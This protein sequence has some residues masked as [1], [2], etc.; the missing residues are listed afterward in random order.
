LIRPEEVLGTFVKRVPFAYPV[1][2]LTY[3]EN[4][5][6]ILDFVH[7]LD[8][9]QTGGRQGLFRYNNMDQSIDMGRRMGWGLLQGDTGLHE[10]VA[11][12]REYFG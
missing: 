12:G 11:T 5:L 6:P 3:K 8:N 9:I 7:S 10:E 1:Y 4:L 2:D